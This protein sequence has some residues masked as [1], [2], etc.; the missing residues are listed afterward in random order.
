MKFIRI[1][2]NDFTSIWEE[3]KLSKLFFVLVFL[4]LSVGILN[5][6]FTSHIIVKT[7]T[8]LGISLIVSA[9]LYMVSVIKHDKTRAEEFINNKY[10]HL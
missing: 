5:C 3:S 9:V 8:V 7:L 2:K 4:T 10:K 1:I 6:Y